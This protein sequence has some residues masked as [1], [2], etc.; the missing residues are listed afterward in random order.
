MLQLVCFSVPSQVEKLQ[1]QLSNATH[2]N[3]ILLSELDNAGMNIKINL[4]VDEITT[5]N[6]QFY[7]F[8]PIH[9]CKVL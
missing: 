7:V 8:S 3:K 9:L 4:E 6:I 2:D 5:D 1:M